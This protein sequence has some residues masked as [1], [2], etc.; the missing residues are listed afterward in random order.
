[1]NTYPKIN[2]L[3]PS[4]AWLVLAAGLLCGA[5]VWWLSVPLTGV[6]EPFDS[7]SLYYLVA[8]FLAG[9]FATLPAPRYWWMAIL[10]IFLG[11]RLYAFLLLPE[12]RSWLLFG[13]VINVLIL[14]WLPAALGAVSVYFVYHQFK[15]RV[16]SHSH[17]Q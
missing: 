7:A 14:S 11:E 9:V 17:N 5:V 10:G 13:I 4:K 1:M 16:G 8:M 12:T 3:S 6:R 2:R 15:K